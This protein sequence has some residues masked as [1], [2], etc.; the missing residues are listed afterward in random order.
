MAPHAATRHVPHA[1]RRLRAAVGGAFVPASAPFAKVRAK[2]RV[3]YGLA[4]MEDL[5]LDRCA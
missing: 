1:V 4:G 3:E 5:D 2:V